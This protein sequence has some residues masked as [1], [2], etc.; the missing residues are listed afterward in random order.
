MS[1]L[2]SNYTHLKHSIFK[3]DL[4]KV[5]VLIETWLIHNRNMFA[6][7]IVKDRYSGEYKENYSENFQRELSDTEKKELINTIFKISQIF[8]AFSDF[9]KSSTLSV[10]TIFYDNDTL[11]DNFERKDPLE[12]FYLNYD[13]KFLERFSQV[14][15][16]FARDGE[17]KNLFGFRKYQNLSNKKDYRVDEHEYTYSIYQGEIVNHLFA[18]ESRLEQIRLTGG[19][20]P[21]REKCKESFYL[22]DAKRSNAPM[23]I[24]N[25]FQVLLNGKSYGIPC[26]PRGQFFDLIGR[27][28]NLRNFS[29][30]NKVDSLD[31]KFYI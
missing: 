28:E 17:S 14:I 31:E 23:K 27:F 22:F 21:S 8:L 5:K 18:I 16:I 10:E 29:Q 20:G 19:E 25:K 15:E 12:S 4:T 9:L 13:C 7:A 3:K 26:P 30:F 1:F 11:K 6:T 24:P 2:E